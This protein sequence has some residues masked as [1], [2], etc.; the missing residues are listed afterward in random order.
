[1]HPIRVKLLKLSQKI[2]T[3]NIGLRQL[4]KL[5]GEEHP[6][7]IKYHLEQMDK[8]GV[9]RRDEN[10]KI[11]VLK[12]AKKFIMPN[13]ITLPIVGYANCGPA[14]CVA[15]QN[16]E[17]Y[18]HTSPGIL[19]KKNRK[20]LFVIK[21]VGNSLNAAQD[22]MGGSVE[23]GDMVIIDKSN[24]NPK[25]GDYVLSIID[26]AANLKRF[27]RDADGTVR[28]VSESTENIPPILIHPDDFASFMING[29]VVRVIKN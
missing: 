28:L 22:V 4:A 24:Q 20:D 25:N 5:V 7:L 2:D 19:G 8:E 29:I 27:Y 21:A 3:S 15:E 12:D 13:I 10:G 16:I 9:I 18:L 6:Q 1:M 11:I 17:G 14:T 23:N 26:D